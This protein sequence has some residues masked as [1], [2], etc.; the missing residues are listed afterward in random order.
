MNGHSVGSEAFDVAGEL[1][2]IGPVFSPGVAESGDFV[3]INTKI[4]HR[5]SNFLPAGVVIVDS[6]RENY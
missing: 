4:C 5:M 1:L 3:D 6:F 2:D